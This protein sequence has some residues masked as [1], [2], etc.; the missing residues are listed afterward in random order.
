M[1]ILLT[2]NGDPSSPGIALAH[3]LR[4]LAL[5]A[6]LLGGAAVP[7]QVPREVNI[8]TFTHAEPLVRPM[9][10]VVVKAYERLGIK[11]TVVRIPIARSLVDA[12][13][14][15]YDAELG[16]TALSEKEVQNLLRLEEPIGE[17]RYTPFVMRGAAVAFKDWESLRQSGLHIGARHGTRVP[18]V[19]LGPALQERPNSTQAL[20]KMLVA[21]HVDVAVGTS[22]T[23]RATLAK[24]QDDGVP[25]VNDVVELAALDVQPMYHYLH[26]RH[27]ALVKPL[28]AAFKKMQQDGSLQKIWDAAAKEEL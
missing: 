5:T 17:I 15:Q 18:E 12:D 6:M 20:F 16:R 23:M 14:G 21:K 27:A 7:A 4:G 26:K 8:A 25:G 9:E 3:A 28:N 11:A 10:R 19:K 22:S 24:M 1:N 2:R 13:A